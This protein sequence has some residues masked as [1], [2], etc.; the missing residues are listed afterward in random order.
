MH[1]LVPKVT[2][3]SVAPE[4]FNWGRFGKLMSDQ[5]T[6]KNRLETGYLEILKKKYPEDFRPKQPPT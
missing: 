6:G 5:L 3:W 4:A 1:I 2:K